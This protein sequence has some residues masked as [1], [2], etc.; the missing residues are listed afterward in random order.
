MIAIHLKA[1]YNVHVWSSPVA[2]EDEQSTRRRE[3]ELTCPVSERRGTYSHV[4]SLSQPND[5]LSLSLCFY[6]L[7]RMIAAARETPL[8]R[9]Q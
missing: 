2:Q 5:S 3:E 6:L 7:E 8:I 9:S 1:A 4:K